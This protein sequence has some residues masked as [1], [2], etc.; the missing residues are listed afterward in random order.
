V[1]G[2]SET[3]KESFSAVKTFSGA[4]CDVFVTTEVAEDGW[5]LLVSFKMEF[6][7]R[8]GGGT[9]KKFRE[10]RANNKT[11]GR[12]AFRIP[13]QGFD[14]SYMRLQGRDFRGCKSGKKRRSPPGWRASRV[15]D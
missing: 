11:K 7:G 4:V 2:F 6:S 9:L 1:N 13:L 8:K 14:I 5:Q 10:E 3:V 15:E 12:N